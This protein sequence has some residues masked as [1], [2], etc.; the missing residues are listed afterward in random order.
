MKNSDK[1]LLGVGLGLIA[2]AAAGHYLAS[3]EGKK[4]QHDTKQKFNELNETVQHKLKES[5]ETTANKLNEV[6]EKAKTWADDISNTVKEKIYNAKDS[7]EDVAEEVQNDFES[8]ISKAKR[9]I[10]ARENT[11]SEVIN[12]HNN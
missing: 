9:V 3:P 4:F 5:S 7:V 11:I 2:G 12:N 10:K 6:S 1:V 8:G